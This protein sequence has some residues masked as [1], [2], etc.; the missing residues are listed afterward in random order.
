MASI[1]SPSISQA[2]SRNNHELKI[3]PDTKNETLEVVLFDNNA[4]DFFDLRESTGNPSYIDLNNP[5][6]QQTGPQGDKTP[7]GCDTNRWIS[8][9]GV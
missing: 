6:E 1:Y 5:V 8:G 4:T 3:I 7:I 9:D 2:G